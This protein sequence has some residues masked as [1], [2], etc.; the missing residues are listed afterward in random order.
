MFDIQIFINLINNI[1]K[2]LQKLK[3][4]MSE[5]WEDHNKLMP[6]VT[7]AGLLKLKATKV[8]EM[9]KACP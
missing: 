6:T 7:A 9:V 1:S 4:F 5:A 2:V 3:E 8:A